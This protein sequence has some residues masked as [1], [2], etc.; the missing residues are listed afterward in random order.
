MQTSYSLN[1]PQAVLGMTSEDFQKYVQT[2]IPS[3]TVAPGRLLVSDATANKPAN[4]AKYPT[5]AAEVRKAIGVTMQDFTREGGVDFAANR[6]IPAV[7]KGRIWVTA[8]G[9]IARWS[10]VYARFLANGA[11]KLNLGAFRADYDGAHAALVEGAMALT[12]AL[13]GELFLLELDLRVQ[14]P[15]IIT[16]ALGAVSTKASDN[17]VL[18]GA[19]PKTGTIVGMKSTLLAVLATADATL[20]LKAGANVAG[21]ANVGSTTTGKITI[22]STG[23]AGDVDSCA[24]LTDNIAVTEGDLLK[25]EV[26]GGSTATGTAAVEVEIEIA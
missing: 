20:Q 14:K 26:G 24:P 19:V 7:R 18:Y 4:Y 21:L 5:T 3:L 15:Q 9:A 2:V 23:A 12:D 16:V 6:P 1:A 8:E 17:G 25:V 22:T 13:A 11:G 10:P